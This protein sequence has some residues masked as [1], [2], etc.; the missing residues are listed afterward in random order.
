MST[1]PTGRLT[2]LERLSDAELIDLLPTEKIYKKRG[3]PV[4]INRTPQEGAVISELWRRY[5]IHRIQ[6]ETAEN[7]AFMC[8]TQLIKLDAFQ[9]WVLRITVMR[10]AKNLPAVFSDLPPGVYLL[11]VPAPGPS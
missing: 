9:A 4:Q 6:K 5:Q 1:A 3:K 11:A 10:T 7:I 2:C 8:P